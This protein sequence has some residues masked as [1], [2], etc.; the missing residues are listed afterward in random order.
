[1]ARDKTLKYCLKCRQTMNADN[2]YTSR[3]PDRYPP[4]GKLPICKDC[5]T[6]HVDPWDE[7]TFMDL[8]KDLDIPY[9]PDVWG[10]LIAAKG[11]SPSEVTGRYIMG[12]YIARMRLS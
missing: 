6:M 4:D 11:G 10:G 1:M 2:F 9:L 12:R 8:L 5:A 3:D 7:S